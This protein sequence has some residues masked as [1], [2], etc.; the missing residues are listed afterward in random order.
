MIVASLVAVACAAAVGCGSSSKKARCERGFGQMK[1]VVTTMAKGMGMGDE[2]A[3]ELD[4]AKP[5]FMAVCVDLPDEAVNCIANFKDK[6]TDEKCMAVLEDVKKD[7]NKKKGAESAAKLKFEPIDVDHKRVTAMVPAGWKHEDG[8]GDTFEPPKEAEL[9]F[10]TRMEIGSTCGGACDKR[11]AA[12][13]EKLVG[14]EAFAVVKEEG[15]KILKD[16]KIGATGR[17]AVYT[18]EHGAPAHKIAA[19]F[20]SEGGEQY[21]YC[22]AQLDDELEGASAVFEQACRDTKV[23]SFASSYGE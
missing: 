17:I 8:F 1:D 22:R 16:E 2:A 13:W 12:E 18:K 21:V 11:T 4:K 7:M 10:F 19:A 20:W 9:G 15:V 23:K 6:M 3:K 5:E 14:D